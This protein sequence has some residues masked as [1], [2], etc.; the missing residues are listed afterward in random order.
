MAEI[1]IRRFSTFSPA[2]LFRS[3]EQTN[4]R[5]AHG[6]PGGAGCSVVGVN[7]PTSRYNCHGNFLRSRD[8]RFSTEQRSRASETTRE[9]RERGPGGGGERE[10]ETTSFHSPGRLL[11]S[12]KRAEFVDLWISYSGH[13]NNLSVFDAKNFESNLG[14]LKGDD[15]KKTKG[16]F[17]ATRAFSTMV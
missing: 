3:A 10:T 16:E 1:T 4:A 12:R 6:A 8:A 11:F 15:S 2:F 9:T 7:K 14:K 5:D 13:E 17:S